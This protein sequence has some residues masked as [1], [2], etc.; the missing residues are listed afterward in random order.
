MHVAAPVK[1]RAAVERAVS[2]FENEGVDGLLVVMLTSGPA[3]RV[4][5]AL[6]ETRLPVC[7]ANLQPVPAITA[8]WDMGDL[9]YNQGIHGAQDTANAMVQA[10]RPFHVITDDWRA[11]SFE[12]EVG[13]WA[14]A[15]AA[16]S[17][18]R[19]L[20]VAVLGYAMNGMGDIRVDIHTLLR[21]LGP[22]IDSIA[23]GD[24]VRAAAAVEGDDLARLIQEEN[25]RFEID[26]RLSVAEREDH[27]R[28]QLGLERI[29][30]DGGYSA[31]STHFGAVAEDGRFT[32]LPLAAASSLMA[33]GYGYAAEGDGLTAALMS[34]A[35]ILIGETQFTEMYAMDFPR[36]AFL[37]SHFRPTGAF[38]VTGPTGS[39]KSTTIYAALCDVLR[40][41]INVITIEDPVEYQLPDVYQL[42]V[43]KRAGLTF[44]TGLRAILRSDPDV[45]MVGEIRD[46]ETAKITLE[47]A[48]TG[49]AV[50]STLHT[51]DAPG[52]LTRLKDLGVE[53]AMT[54]SAITA[55]LAQRLARRVCEECREPYE[56]SRTDLE[57]LGF[58]PAAIE[59]GVTLYRARG[60]PRCTKGY[61]GRTGIHQLMVVDD[62]I[63]RLAGAGHQELLVAAIAGGMGTLWQDGPDKA[64]LG[65][66]TIE[67]ISRVVR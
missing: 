35:Q 37:M 57:H 12:H 67:E 22:Q 40:P 45:L 1:D 48:L 10:G 61:R 16:V 36:D 26:P 60:C 11:S 52:A 51:N 9:T 5:R 64:A 62:D 54:A 21:T 14:R 31:Y 2:E 53:P 25:E 44:A 4:A 18:W 58:T 20:K 17:R 28:M 39:G 56:S 66:T 15:A 50:F 55:V 13:R 41:E 42:Q 8:E 43:N 6:A 59:R 38:L 7:L 63:A 30:V 33:K 29:L 47:A 23:P 34:A 19:Q 32:R 49:H 3:M 65:V 27:A 46:L 24:L